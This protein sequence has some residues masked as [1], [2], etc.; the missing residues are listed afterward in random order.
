LQDDYDENL[1][2]SLEYNAYCL[3]CDEQWFDWDD[4]VFKLDP[5]RTGIPEYDEEVLIDEP[6]ELDVDSIWDLKKEKM[7]LIIHFIINNKHLH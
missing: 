4:W 5:E 3:E 6:P 2:N 1:E 7:C